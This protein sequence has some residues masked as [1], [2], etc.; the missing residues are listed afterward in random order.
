MI[1]H[2][3]GRTPQRITWNRNRKVGIDNAD[4]Q[5]LSKNALMLS[6]TR[7]AVETSEA[8]NFVILTFREV[9]MLFSEEV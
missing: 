8:R 3:T 2:G 4:E 7:S 9:H 1:L 5:I 6:R